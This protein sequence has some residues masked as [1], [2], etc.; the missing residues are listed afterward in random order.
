M[1]NSDYHPSNQLVSHPSDFNTVLYKVFSEECSFVG[2]ASEPRKFV[3]DVLV[4]PKV[5]VEFD[6]RSKAITFRQKKG[7]AVLA[8]VILN[9]GLEV[10]AICEGKEE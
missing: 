5:V 7:G 4:V 3:T 1:I 8:V 2:N 6:R 9:R 10:D